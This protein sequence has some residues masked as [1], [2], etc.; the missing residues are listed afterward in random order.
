MEEHIDLFKKIISKVEQKVDYV[1]IRA[2]KGTNSSI[3]MKDSKIQEINSGISLGARIRVLNNGSWGF[4][5]TND[6]TKLE[7]ISETAIKI[8]NALTGDIELSEE[9]IIED[10]IKSQA[11]I[12]FK[13]VSIDEKKEIIAEAD[14]P[15]HIDKKGVDISTTISYSDSEA[16]NAFVI[17]M[18]CLHSTF[19][20]TRK[21]IFLGVR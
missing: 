11:K 16:K 19:L 3:I 14:K 4:A 8:S 2:G 17:Q 1:D 7:E 21:N 10:K 6:F 15:T 18:P 13:D 12:Q 5:Y 20:F 9:E